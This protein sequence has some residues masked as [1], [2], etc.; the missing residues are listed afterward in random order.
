MPAL[1]TA[2]VLLLSTLLSHSYHQKVSNIRLY[3]QKLG[4]APEVTN[5]DP[6]GVTFVNPAF[7]GVNHGPRKEKKR[8]EGAEQARDGSSIARFQ[9]TT[10]SVESA[11][12]QLSVS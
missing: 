8:V 6:G 4:C 10:M 3:I 5:P 11:E 1:L 12:R 7:C 9:V 2:L